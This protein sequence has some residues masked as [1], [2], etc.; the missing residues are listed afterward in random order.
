MR[1]TS[2]PYDFVQTTMAL[3]H[4]TLDVRHDTGFSAPTLDGFELTAFAF[5]HAADS[6][7]LLPGGFD[8]T[9]V[10]DGQTVEAAAHLWGKFPA[11]TGLTATL[12]GA[13]QP[14]LVWTNHH[15]GRSIDST[16]VFR[17]A[18]GTGWLF[19]SRVVGDSAA[20]KD[21]LL[22]AG[23]YG[24]FIRHV[25]SRTFPN[26]EEDRLARPNS[27]TTDSV[28]VAINPLQA[29]SSLNCTGATSTTAS[30]TWTNGEAAESVIVER[31]N[32]TAWP[33][34]AALAAGTTQ[35]TD[36]GLHASVTYSYRVRHRHGL[37]MSL[38]SAFDNATTPLPEA[39]V[40]L[41]CVGQWWLG[42]T[43]TWVNSVPAD[44]THL[45][46]GGVLTKRL[47]PG[48][49]GW[50]DTLVIRDSTYV[51]QVKHVDLG[52]AGP[53]GPPD[54]TVANQSGPD[55]LSCGRTD[56]TTATCVWMNTDPGTNPIEV[57]RKKG[58]KWSLRTTLA[59]SAIQFDDTGLIYGQAYTYRLRYKFGSLYSLWSAEDQIDPRDPEP[60]GPPGGP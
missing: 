12:V 45:Y 36:T 44:S 54:T 22:A 57:W 26:V 35:H 6:S 50:T 24:Y 3:D 18:N 21:T 10:F 38:P 15:R 53:L 59:G 29:P 20:W 7:G 16:E 43:C 33:Q 46:R 39:P 34:V 32:G 13:N 30:C 14:R 55:N 49:T 31:Q 19:R 17:N 9:T 60:Y 8:S 47:G 28:G 25:T 37:L 2:Q 42:I 52:V 41:A 11:P 40:S 4:I 27:P 23:T 1:R 56:S 51:Y 58:S 5:R 48:A